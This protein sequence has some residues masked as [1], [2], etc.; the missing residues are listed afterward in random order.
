MYQTH[1]VVVVK[2]AMRVLPSFIYAVEQRLPDCGL[3]V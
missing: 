2:M 1:T 3:A